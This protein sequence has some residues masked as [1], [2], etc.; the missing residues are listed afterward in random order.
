NDFT[1]ELL[2]DGAVVD[3]KAPNS[4]KYVSFSNITKGNYTLRVKVNS[5]KSSEKY[6]AVVNLDQAG[7]YFSKT[8]L[9]GLDPYNL[10]N[11]AGQRK[12]LNDFVSEAFG[13]RDAYNF[14]TDA[15]HT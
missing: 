8:D 12:V 9:E 2:K 3:T 4:K 14:T 15:D 5:T 13:D 7:N 10:G 11:I 6:Q 1:V